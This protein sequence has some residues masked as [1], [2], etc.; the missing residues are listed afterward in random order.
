MLVSQSAGLL[1]ILALS[2]AAEPRKRPKFLDQAPNLTVQGD[3]APTAS[4][5]EPIKTTV[6]VNGESIDIEAHS[7]DHI[8]GLIDHI[9]DYICNGPYR[10]Q[11]PV[12][13][14]EYQQSEDG[15]PPRPTHQGVAIEVPTSKAGE[16]KANP[17]MI[18]PVVVTS[19]IQ[20]DIAQPTGDGSPS[21]PEKTKGS[22][23]AHA[24]NEDTNDD[25]T[26]STARHR[27]R[28]RNKSRSH[29]T[30]RTRRRVHTARTSRAPYQWT[31]TR[32]LPYKTYLSAVRP[33]TAL[34]ALGNG[35]LQGLAV[36]RD[37]AD[38]DRVEPRIVFAN[39]IVTVTLSSEHPH[40]AAREPQKKPA[41][42][43]TTTTKTTKTTA[44]TGRCFS[45]G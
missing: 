39:E 2:V 8:Q 28:T 12:L 40:L 22:E 21:R 5:T 35:Q 14:K 9:E 6:V 3:P 32:T 20:E 37:D 30:S 7:P 36:K 34:A 19:W 15:G 17:T 16:I 25:N 41:G 44:T 26:T 42:K 24:A 1:A 38:V 31:G 27:R 43:T 33:Q 18:E 10:A 23:V 11:F 29:P 13:C 45:T 4:A